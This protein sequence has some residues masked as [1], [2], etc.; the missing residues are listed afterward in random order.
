[1]SMEGVK[2]FR[3]ADGR[4]IRVRMTEAEQD[5]QWLFNVVRIALPVASFF[6]LVA[7]AGIH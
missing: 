6:I 4:V 3:T 7:A 1:M 2:R 5:E